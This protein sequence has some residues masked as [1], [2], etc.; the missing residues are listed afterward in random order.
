MNIHIIIPIANIEKQP[1]ND[2]WEYTHNEIIS[3][4]SNLTIDCPECETIIH[5]DE[6]Y[7]CGTCG[8]GSKIYVLDWLRKQS[9]QISLDEKAIE[10]KALKSY[11]HEHNWSKEE[12]KR[13]TVIDMAENSEFIQGYKQALKD[14]I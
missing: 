9:K 3:R 4:L 13:E 1:K 5:S 12:Q 7:Q 11:Y 14:L 6:Q 8:G 2:G 10:E